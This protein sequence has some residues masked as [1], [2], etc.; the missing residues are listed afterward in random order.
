MICP[1]NSG[2]YGEVRYLNIRFPNIDG[3]NGKTI[4]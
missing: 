4:S 3:N 1:D 2:N